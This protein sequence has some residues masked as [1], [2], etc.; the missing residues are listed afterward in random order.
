[1]NGL[2]F[3]YRIDY[4]YISVSLLIWYKAYYITLSFF[5]SSKIELFVD[6]INNL[7]FS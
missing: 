2:A 6:I 1:M 4:N 5:P 7:I 3:H